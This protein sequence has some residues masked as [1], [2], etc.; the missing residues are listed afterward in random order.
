[1]E[2]INRFRALAMI[3]SSFFLL[4][5]IL[6]LL[7]GKGTSLI[8]GGSSFALLIGL[9][10]FVDYRMTAARLASSKFI[11]TYII[12]YLLLCTLVV[13][14]TRG[15]EES[16]Y[17][18]VYFLPIVIAA[19]NL[20]LKA[21]LA[22][23]SA[24]L[25][26]FISHLPPSM[27]LVRKERIEEFPELFGFG[28]MF[29]M[30][31]ILV[32][33]FAHQHRRQLDL[34]QQ[35]NE[36]L[37]ENQ[38]NLKNSLE[39]LEI[40]ETSLRTKERLASLGEMSAGIAHEIR[41][42]LGIISSS[43]QLLKNEI[44]N[45]DAGQLLDIIQEESARL[46]GLITDFL[47]FG[48]QLEPQCQSCD[49]ATLVMRNLEHLHSMAEQKRVRLRLER[50][51]EACEAFVDADMMQQVVLNLLLNALDATTAEGEIV[52]T[53]QR[54][55]DRLEVFVQDNG[56]GIQLADQ[57]KI[58]DPFFTTKSNGTGLG[59]ANAYKIVE[60]HNGSLTVQSVPGEGS[61]FKISLPVEGS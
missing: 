26:M 30:V 15:N 54:T 23:C 35:L 55:D 4:L 2:D 8:Y 32:Y 20:G 45:V 1:M 31:G 18:I 16:P 3:Q 25:L 29:F 42:P 19:S 60:S 11:I 34:K 58:Y 50:R 5:F 33:T 61:I 6:L 57:E 43:A 51:C 37:L 59:L 10:L 36:K 52:V 22:T 21:T 47:I 48:R 53:V 49:L 38:Q 44:A 39:R 41:N 9:H 7:S 28:I 12:I 24:A 17:W 40:A 46:N 27:Y 14:T 13:W 56:C